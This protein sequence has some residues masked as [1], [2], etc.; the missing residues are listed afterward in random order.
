MKKYIQTFILA[1]GVFSL[2]FAGNPDRQGEAGATELLLNPW[3]RSAGLHSMTTSFSS[4]VEAMRINVAGISRINSGE[5]QFSNTRLYEGS[6]L[7]MTAFGAAFKMGNGAL[8][9][10]FTGLNFGD[11]PITTTSQ[12]DGTGGIYSP[13]FYNLA[14][15]YSYTFG[16]DN[17]DGGKISVGALVRGVSETLPDV[18]SFGIGIDAG[19]QYI[20]GEQD[21]F[22][23]GVSLRNVGSPMEF[24]GEG[25]TFTSDDPGSS[26]YGI[27]VSN[28]GEDFEL[29]TVLDIGVSYDFY[30]SDNYLRLLSN[31]TSNAFSQDQIGVG[32]EFNF[33]KLVTLRG[34][35][36]YNFGGISL[37]KDIYTGLAAGISIDV[38][39]RRASN[40]KIGLDYA[41]RTTNHYAGTHN[42]A[43]RFRF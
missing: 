29:P 39:L 8:G 23:L 20:S 32:A 31:F 2:A 6:S 34:G 42:F 12:P 15:G 14:V 24:G 10:S 16:A 1:F 28:L 38:P 30:M 37:G 41:Y 26:S 33:R 35:Y 11:I 4:G 5:L 21:N 13:G 3:A 17:E 19:V 18:N 22:K 27:K 7:S 43:L 36:K 40:Q 25:L 9:I